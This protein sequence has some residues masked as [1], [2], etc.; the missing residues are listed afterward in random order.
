MRVV[1]L[2]YV[3]LSESDA[4]EKQLLLDQTIISW[5][6]QLVPAFC[7][8]ALHDFINVHSP[9]ALNPLARKADALVANWPSLSRRYPFS[10][11]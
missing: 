3:G 1:Y 9:C 8:G 10:S 6:I 11:G 2:L 5:F 4:S 7:V